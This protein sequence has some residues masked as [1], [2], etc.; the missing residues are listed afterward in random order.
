M[1]WS[2]EDE[3][4]NKTACHSHASFSKD[5]IKGGVIGGIGDL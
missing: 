1:E 3:R 5:V 2:N 4:V